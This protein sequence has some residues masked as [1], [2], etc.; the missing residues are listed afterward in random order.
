MA[1]I[2]EDY[3]RW[4]A[5]SL[6]RL[7][8]QK[9][10][11]DPNFTDFI[12]QDSN[13]TTLIDV[14]AYMYDTMT[15]YLNH[16]ASEAMFTDARLYENMNR[17]VK[18]LGYNPSGFSS[19]VIESLFITRSE[20]LENPDNSAWAGVQ[21]KILPKYT[22]IDTGLS[23]SR[24]RQIFYSLE[25]VRFLEPTGGVFSPQSEDRTKMVNGRWKLFERTFVSEGIPFETIELTSLN[26][27]TTDPN[28]ETNFV[29][30]PYIDVFVRRFDGNSGEFEFIPFK[31][32]SEGTIFTDTESVFTSKDNVFEL[33]INEREKYTLTFGDDIHGSRLKPSDEIYIIYLEG[34]GEDAEINASTLNESNGDITLSI[35][36]MDNNTYLQIVG[37]NQDDIPTQDQLEEIYVSNVT[38]STQFDGI[39]DVND[40][41]RNAPDWFRMGQRLI[42]QTDFE[43]FI[44]KEY[45]ED[46]FDVNAMNNWEY[47]I[48]FLG[49]LRS[50]RDCEGGNRLKPDIRERDYPFVDSC[51]FNNVYIWAK[52]KGQAINSDLIEQDM[53]NRKCLTSEP[54]VLKALD[55]HF[56]PCLSGAFGDPNSCIVG[57]NGY[58]YRYVDPDDPTRRGWDPDAENFIELTKD[59]S[60]VVTPE[61]VKSDATNVLRDFFKERN[62][63]IGGIVDLRELQSNLL[64]IEGV[65]FVKTVYEKT[66][67]NEK[68]RAEFNGLSFAAWTQELAGGEDKFVFNGNV[69]LKNFQFPRLTNDENLQI[70][71]R[72]KVVFESF[73]S[74]SIEY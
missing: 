65:A 67:N 11:E 21:Q 29:A 37:V 19:P 36:G 33:R 41:R 70:D 47:S 44:L 2:N 28:V 42:T 26:L 62:N 69:D 4:D 7:I 10:S 25:N 58:D 55:T 64:N 3:L 73:G 52:F 54:V 40:I 59:N 66:V 31:A 24:G 22:S 53:L 16:G 39:E 60:S 18:M 68:I 57:E 32:I 17:I 13:L 1:K 46:L 56:V 61:K 43:Q 34:N 63:T 30:H 72:I 14:F 5:E 48:E 15:Y 27:K 71:K 6:K 20:F 23:D 8:V 45:K 38:E 49:W 51:D 12:F 74:P 9:L 35:A 50:I